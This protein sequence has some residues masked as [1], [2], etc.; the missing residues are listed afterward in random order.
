MKNI[1]D[2]DSNLELISRECIKINLDVKDIK[3]LIANLTEIFRDY[4]K[5]K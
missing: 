5:I 4:I 3:I 2:I 1:H